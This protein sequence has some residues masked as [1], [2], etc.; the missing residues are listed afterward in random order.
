MLLLIELLTNL[1][2]KCR[3]CV[4]P[5]FLSINIEII[6]FSDTIW[7]ISK[8]YLSILA[9]LVSIINKIQIAFEVIVNFEGVWVF[10]KI[11]L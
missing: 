10:K 7:V 2:F 1:S 3:E 6:V 8:T 11:H 9:T 4:S 5:Q